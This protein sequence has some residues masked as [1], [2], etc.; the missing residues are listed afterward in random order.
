VVISL[1]GGV[2]ACLYASR[3]AALAVE[4]CRQEE[5]AYW[6]SRLLPMYE[7]VPDFRHEKN[8]RTREELFD[9]LFRLSSVVR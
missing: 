1:L 8:P 5:F 9:P 7:R 2:G 3:A 6:R 4:E